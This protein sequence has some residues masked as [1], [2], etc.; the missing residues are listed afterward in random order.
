MAGARHG[1]RAVARSRGPLG[2]AMT[3]AA[4]GAWWWAGLRLLTHPPLSG[5]VEGL[6]IAGAWGLSLL[7]VHCVPR[8]PRKGRGEL[9]DQPKT[10]RSRTP[11]S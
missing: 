8:T 3:A 1:I 11:T 9:R 4:T 10:T 2:W 6:V 5:P 7:P